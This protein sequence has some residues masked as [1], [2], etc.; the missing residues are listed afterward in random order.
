MT[1]DLNSPENDPTDYGPYPVNRAVMGLKGK[2]ENEE[3]GREER[4]EGERRQRQ[5]KRKTVKKRW[6]RSRNKKPKNYFT[7]LVC[8][9][10][11]CMYV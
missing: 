9:F 5:R 11:V 3:R 6:R 10:C 1:F 4:E 8:F 2:Q 7:N